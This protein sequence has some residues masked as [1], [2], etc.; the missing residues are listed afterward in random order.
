MKATF[1]T[2]T[3]NVLQ[4]GESVFEHTKKIICGDWDSMRIPESFANFHT[5]IVN[6]LHPIEI[7]KRYNIY[8]DCG[9]PYCLEIDSE[10]K[11]H[12]PSHEVI[13]K[14]LWEHLF[15]NDPIVSRLIGYDM[16]L[17]KETAET[18]T[19]LNLSKADASTLMVTSLAEI[20]SNAKLFGGIESISFKSKW[21]KLD[22]RIKML[23]KAL[24]QEPHG[25]SYVVVRNDL[26]SAQKGV[27]GA[28]CSI[29]ARHLHHPS[30]IY[31]VVK[32]EKKLKTVM[33]QVLEM[34]VRF[35]IFREPDLGN[36]ITGFA[37][38]PLFDGQRDFFKK[39]QLL[40]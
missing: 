27:Q 17:H 4:H 6:N 2:P 12:F 7:V 32:D 20:H 30:V 16:V 14:S 40:K 22:Q 39:F 26:T 35:F 38:E 13:S 9:K 37:T 25:Y 11:S 33:A 5:E 15:P 10:G 34:G 31:V 21:K 24:F 19:S 3:Q 1:Q 18:I 29:E 28:H 8:H 23:T 36:S